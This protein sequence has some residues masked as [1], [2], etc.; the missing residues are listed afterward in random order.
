M[1]SHKKEIHVRQNMRTSFLLAALTC[2]SLCASQAGAWDL[3]NPSFED[4]DEG[5]ENTYGDLSANWGRWGAWMNRE[6]GWKPVRTGKCVTGYH[7]WE[8]E[9]DGTSG[10]YQDVAD[11]PSGKSYTFTAHVMKDKDTDAE[12]IEMRL[13]LFGGATTVASVNYP[14]SELKAGEWTQLSVSGTPETDGIRVL[15]IITPKQGGDRH[16][17]IKID[18]TSLKAD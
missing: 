18:D 3:L 11:T 7:H 13:E 9:E 10:I 6:T 12:N 8:I 15:V 4:A 5:A 16:G 1:R 17:A 14:V 2:W